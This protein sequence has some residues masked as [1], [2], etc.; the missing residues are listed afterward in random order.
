MFCTNN[1]HTNMFTSN[2]F[3]IKICFLNFNYAKVC[4][5]LFRILKDLNFKLM[6]LCE[7]WIQFTSFWSDMPQSS[8]Y[9]LQSVCYI[10]TNSFWSFVTSLNQTCYLLWFRSSNWWYRLCM[11]KLFQREETTSTWIVQ[12]ETWRTKI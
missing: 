5:N 11:R 9:L 1:Q 6:K 7:L 10:E 3:H 12:R 4:V 2:Y 8:R